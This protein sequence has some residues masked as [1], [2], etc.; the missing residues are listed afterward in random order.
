MRRGVALALA[1]IALVSPAHAR[2]SPEGAQTWSVDGATSAI[3][4]EDHRAPLVEV[5]LMFPIGR[6]SPWVK[7][8]GRLDEAFALQLLDFNQVFKRMNGRMLPF[9]W[10]KFLWYKRKIPSTRVLTLGVK[11]EHRHKGIDALLILQLHIEAGKLGCPRGEC[12]WILEDNMPMWRAI[13]RLG[14][15]K[16]LLIVAHR[17]ATVRTCD[18]IYVLAGGRVC[19][20]GTFEELM[21]RSPEFREMARAPALDPAVGA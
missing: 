2:L 15:T 20:R 14:G 1:S 4:V 7:R 16:T 13:E 6:W 8:A 10:A 18:V 3:L 5:R 21:E 9:G 11:P 17:L 19:D 12:S